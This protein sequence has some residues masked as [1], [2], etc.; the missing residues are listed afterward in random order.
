MTNNALR[1]RDREEQEN[2]DEEPINIAGEDLDN[3]ENCIYKLPLSIFRN[4]LATHFDINFK[5][6]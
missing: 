1:F 3:N 5:Q 4:K 6:G 2:V